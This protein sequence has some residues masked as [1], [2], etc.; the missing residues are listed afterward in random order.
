[1]S[2]ILLIEDS[3][4]QALTYRRLLEGAGHAVRHAST[5]AEAFA[6]CGESVPDLVLLDQFLGDLSG[7]EV[8][9][10]LKG[11]LAL[12]V[13]PIVVLTAS[14]KERDHVAALDAGADRFLSKDSAPAE[15]LAVIE[16]LLRSTAAVE[17]MSHDA[18]QQDGF[19]KDSRILA[20][21]DSRVYLAEIS[22]QLSACGFQVTTAQS[23]E[24]GLR[25][26]REG[27]FHAAVVDVVMPEMDGFEVCRAARLWASG[28]QKQLGL[29]VL[30]GQENR[31]VLLQALE[32][33]ADDFVS[34][35]QDV[36]IIL[37]HVKSLVRRVRMMRHI[38]SISQKS[39]LQELA[40]KEA[41]WRRQQAEERARHADFQAQTV[42]ELKT[43]N[44]RLER[45]RHELEAAKLA[46]ESANQAKSEFLANMSHEIRTPMNG[47]IGM[48][49][50]LMNTELSPLQKDYL[51]LA[52]QSAHALLR[53]LN[54]I[55][56]FSKI[57][58]GKLELE[59]V[60]FSLQECFGKAVRLL[61][62]R[63]EEKG[64]ELAC[65]IDPRIPDRLV[66]DP[67]RLRQIIVN[68]VGN[69]IKFTE[70]GEVVVDA[71]SE[72]IV[73]GTARLHVKVRDTGIGIP[74]EKQDRLFQA[75]SQAD[76]STT[77]KY[78]GT[79][80]GLAI[81]A[82]LVDMMEGRIWPESEPGRG[83]TFHFTG[84]FAVAAN[85]TPPR[86]ADLAQLQRLPVLVVDDNATNR[87]ILDELLKHWGMSPT[88]AADGAA[89]LQQFKAAADQGRPFR[90]IVSDFE[91]PEMNGLELAQ[92][93]SGLPGDNCPVLI[94][95]SSIAGREAQRIH[96]FGAR[97]LLHKPVM[98]SELLD[99]MLVE[100]GMSDDGMETQDVER[101]T[102][103]PR[104]I[105]LA[106]DS[107]IN[108]RVALGFLHRWGHRVTVVTNG[109]E[110]VEALQLQPYDLVLMD[111]QMPVMNGYEA[112]R[113]IREQESRDGRRTPI[114]AMTAEAMKGDREQ[115][116]A[117]GMDDYISKPFDPQALYDQIAAWPAVVLPP[118]DNRPPAPAAGASPPAPSRGAGH[119]VLDWKAA[120]HY[121]GDD[122]QL[123]MQMVDVLREQAPR[124]VEEIRTSIST[125]DAQRLQRSAHSLKGAANYFGAGRVAEAALHLELAG[126]ENRLEDA[127]AMLPPLAAEVD[128]LLEA[129][130]SPRV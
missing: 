51:D 76:A 89:A 120:R 19:L 28:E 25:L 125:H 68:L 81:S 119:A 82:R 96:R 84:V 23:G 90:M 34:K 113:L 118:D 95:S 47:V 85:Q 73:D 102:T 37:A 9:R 35:Q 87:R 49:E 11:D 50:L 33:G 57:E 109:R 115:C 122:S 46:A 26:L 36:E 104:R 111:V 107:P 22:R 112:T 83:T 53:L 103:A 121:V 117:A 14:H 128:R 31:E 60:E 69:A 67:G 86:R 55:L 93:V 105:L 44:A 8:C 100:L 45:S 16:G 127:P 32:S 54:D 92:Q 27:S 124:L 30:S 97:R 6:S 78:G 42:E 110:A 17:G 62:L 63:A 126:R 39:H 52:Q 1:L 2:D 74:R 64:L 41:E 58:A 48:I 101:P 65:R 29:L 130:E 59:Q 72:E 71:A 94:L 80:L 98:S 5:A 75:F 7:L 24:E 114:I 91:M 116:L 21:D 4:I 99:A 38:Q 70:R 13:I 77:R 12:A 106:E 79:G 123:L 3:R 56:D 20:I 18:D 108:Q 10:R 88:L 129:L 40:L 15:L 66:G 61:T 43:L